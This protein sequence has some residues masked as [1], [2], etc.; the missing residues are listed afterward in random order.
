MNVQWFHCLWYYRNTQDIAAENNYTFKQLHS[1]LL[2]LYIPIFISRVL[3]INTPDVIPERHNR[4]LITKFHLSILFGPSIHC[5]L[6]A[7]IVSN[8]S[9]CIICVC[10]NFVT[11][12]DLCRG[13]TNNEA[14]VYSGISREL[15]FT[16]NKGRCLISGSGKIRGISETKQ[17]YP[18]DLVQAFS[19]EDLKINFLRFT[20]LMLRTE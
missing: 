5:Y 8:C 13:L 7:S 11:F 10:C 1:L 16:E 2:L 14:R 12:I 15:T 19:K 18:H 9:S 17:Q 4:V 6:R 3:R 20:R